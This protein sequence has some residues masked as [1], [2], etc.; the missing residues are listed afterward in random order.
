MKVV[1]VIKKHM[2]GTNSLFSFPTVTKKNSVE[3]T[4]N[5][6]HKKVVRSTDIS[7]KL[8]KEFGCLFSIFLSVPTLVNA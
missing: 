1:I 5:G 4:T 3:L 2:K 8:D 6:A 7:N